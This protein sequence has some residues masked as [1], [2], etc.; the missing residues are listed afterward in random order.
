MAQFAVSISEAS[1]L[2]ARVDFS[3]FDGT[4]T[5]GEDYT[6]ASGTLIFPAMSTASQTASVLIQGDLP[7]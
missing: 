6:T 2:P 3:T 1:G 4:A 7:K 5:A